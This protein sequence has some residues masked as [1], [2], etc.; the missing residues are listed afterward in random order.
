MTEGYEADVLGSLY[1]R[2]VSYGPADGY[3]LSYG[4][5]REGNYMRA[6]PNRKATFDHGDTW[7]PCVCGSWLALTDEL[8][9]HL[10]RI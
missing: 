6:V 5:D 7:W 2:R 4:H 10:G 9:E 1:G 8:K 3:W